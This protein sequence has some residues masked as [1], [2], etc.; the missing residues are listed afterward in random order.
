M[1][2]QTPQKKAL[3]LAVD[4]ME[5]IEFCSAVSVLRRAEID[6]T[7]AGVASASPVKSSRSVVITPER[8][9]ADLKS[10][11]DAFDAVVLP[12][13][14]GAAKA[15]SESAEVGSLLK[16]FEAAGKLIA[17]I[18][19]SPSALPAHGVGLGKTVTSHPSV[20]DKLKEGGKYNYSEERVVV[21]RQLI[22]S[23][24]PGTALEFSL[25]IVKNLVG[26]EKAAAVAAPMLLK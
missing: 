19:A 13:G 2:S 1:A 26:E 10:T 20:A 17:I 12:G 23:R 21:D 14:L 24:A 6:V 9:L 11:T 15:F 4:G 25:A 7:I 5:E 8:S 3:I 22:T 16:R 18:C